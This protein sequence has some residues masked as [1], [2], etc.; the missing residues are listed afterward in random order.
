MQSSS[1]D[2]GDACRAGLDFEGNALVAKQ[3]GLFGASDKDSAGIVGIESDA[4]C[5]VDCDG[6]DG[7]EGLWLIETSAELKLITDEGIDVFSG[8]E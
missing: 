1:D 7:D 3:A 5:V 6:F 4:S 2:G 8:P